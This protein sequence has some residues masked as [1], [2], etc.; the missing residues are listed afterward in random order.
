MIQEYVTPPGKSLSRDLTHELNT[1]IDLLV[2]CRP[3]AVSMANTIRRLKMRIHSVSARHAQ[4]QCGL[5]ASVCT[6]RVR[7]VYLLRR[8]LLCGGEKGGGSCAR[9]GVQEWGRCGEVVSG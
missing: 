4:V 9:E 8:G 6:A 7:C 1:I 5:A 2:K 3:L